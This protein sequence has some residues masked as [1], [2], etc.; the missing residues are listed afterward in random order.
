MIKYVTE[1]VEEISNLDKTVLILCKVLKARE[2][3]E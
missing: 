3:S 1:N 2:I